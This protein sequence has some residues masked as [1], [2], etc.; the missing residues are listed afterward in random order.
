MG[1]VPD[2][3]AKKI[4]FFEIRIVDWAAHA[5]EI[6]TTPERVDALADLTALARE[7]YSAQQMAQQAAQAATMRLNDVIGRMSRAGAD[8]IL[9]VRAKAGSVGDSVYPLASLPMPAKGSP[10]G[11]PGLPSE[12]SVELQAATGALRLRWKCRHPDGAVG[13]VYKISR[14][15][16]VDGPFV[17][18]DT[19]GKKTFVDTTVPDNVGGDR[20]SLTY[21][22]QAVRSTAVGQA[23]QFNVTIGGR[24]Q[25]PETMNQV[26]RAA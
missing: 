19:V 21:Q 24:A 17:Y 3:K 14:R 8:I 11:E 10:I 12:F 5:V 23:A 16:G 4:T 9:Q 20:S 15:V 2:S 13:T 18:L 1:V 6:G 26:R 22:V 7:A 25:V